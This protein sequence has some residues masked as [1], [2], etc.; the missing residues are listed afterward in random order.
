M[1]KEKRIEL[2]VPLDEDCNYFTCPILI[3]EFNKIEINENYLKENGY[4]VVNQ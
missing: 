2:V 3:N 4:K 1:K